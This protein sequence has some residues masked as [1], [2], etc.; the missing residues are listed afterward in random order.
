[1][2]GRARRIYVPLGSAAQERKT[3]IALQSWVGSRVL[4][5]MQTLAICSQKVNRMLR[6]GV[7]SRLVLVVDFDSRKLKGKVLE[8]G[9]GAWSR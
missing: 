1:M 5:E 8:M 6:E 2:R 4:R 7:E 3:T 9:I